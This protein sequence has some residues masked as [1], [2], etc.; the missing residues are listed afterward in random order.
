MSNEYAVMRAMPYQP[1]KI[2]YP[3]MISPNIDGV[4]GVFR[5][6]K[7]YTPAGHRLLGLEHIEAKL[8]IT[9]ISYD[10]FVDITGMDPKEAKGRI[11]S[12]KKCPQACYHIIDSPSIAG[13]FGDRF[14]TL[15]GFPFLR[16]GAIQLV[17][18]ILAC[19]DQELLRIFHTCKRLGYN[20]IIAKSKNYRYVTRRSWDWVKIEEEPNGKK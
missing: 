13:S 10:G 19:D 18:H 7:M 11:R 5:D 14:M 9:R 4:R 1:G 2:I 16:N 6:G 17:P 12:A 3:C 8:S 20:G 15:Q